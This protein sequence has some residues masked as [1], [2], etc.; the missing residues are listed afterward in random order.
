MCS[1]LN[2]SM[3]SDMNF[4]V[5]LGIVIYFFVRKLRQ[6]NVFFFL[7]FIYLPCGTG[8]NI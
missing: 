3:K 2:K 1:R 4:L 8:D 7:K 5:I 6:R